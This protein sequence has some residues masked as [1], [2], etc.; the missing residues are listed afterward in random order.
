M[1]LGEIGVITEV[2]ETNGLSM[3]TLRR[4]AGKDL[5]ICLA[6]TPEVT[7]G[8]TVLAQLGFSVETLS[9]AAADDSLALRA[10]GAELS[11]GSTP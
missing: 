7:A 1:C 5:E 2:W 3:G 8:D 9:P 6:Y 10:R 4:A 11:G